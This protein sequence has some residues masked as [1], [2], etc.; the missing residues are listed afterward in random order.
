MDLK[1][2]IWLIVGLIVGVIGTW[3]AMRKN[4]N[5]YPPIDANND[6]EDIASPL[7]S[8][9]TKRRRILLIRK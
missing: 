8:L 1:I 3:L 4:A 6:I 5:K 9:A 2:L 7:S